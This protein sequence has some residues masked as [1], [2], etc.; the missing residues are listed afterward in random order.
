M[1]AA[2]R[3]LEGAEHRLQESL[4]DACS[5]RDAASREEARAS[6][7]HADATTKTEVRARR[8]AEIMREMDEVAVALQALRAAELGGSDA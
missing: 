8:C 2:I 3:A 4:N 7:A 6:K 5:D 1:S